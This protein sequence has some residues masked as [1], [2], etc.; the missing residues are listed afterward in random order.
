M[1]A[2]P[3][4]IRDTGPH[5]QAVRITGNRPDGLPDGV[6][7]GGAWLWQGE[8]FKPL[9]GRPYANCENHY[10][11]QE[12]ECL[13]VFGG[14]PFFPRNWRVEQHNGRRFLVRA[15]AKILEPKAIADE[16]LLLLFAQV[17]KV[18]EGGWEIGDLISLGELNGQ[19]FIVDLSTAH[20]QRGK[21]AYAADDS[22]HVQRYFELAGR[23]KLYSR[24]RGWEDE[25]EE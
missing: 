21:C 13:E 10:P 4:S 15:F 17:N 3:L 18:N 16:T 1:E 5:P 9:D 23:Q 8:I 12:A 11:T 2:L 25:G 14:Q 7:T 24:L 20:P 22:H 19:L 6:H